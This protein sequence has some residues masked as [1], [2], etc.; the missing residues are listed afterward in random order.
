MLRRIIP[1]SI[2]TL[3]ILATLSA[4][5]AAQAV[6]VDKN[7]VAANGHDLVAYFTDQAAVPGKADITAQ[8]EGAT[9]RF[10]TAEHRDA[11]V[12]D[13]LHFL[14]LYGGYCAYG[15]SNGYKV[16]T[17]PDAFTVVDGK[18]YL[19]Y[20]QGV[21]TKWRKDIPGYIAKANVSWSKIKDAPRK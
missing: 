8:Y 7:G 1:T 3:A 18:L 6:N 11:F 19:N 13:P 2:L 12:A 17:D 10:A 15:V 5:V 4:P 14:P 9:Y 20:D 21:M 16:K